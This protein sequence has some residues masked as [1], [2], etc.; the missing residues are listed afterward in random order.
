MQFGY[1]CT[2]V[3]VKNCSPAHTVTVKR[4]S[5]IDDPAVRLEICRG[6][7][8][9]NLGNTQR[10]LWHNVAHGLH[11]YRLTSQ[12][13]PLATHPITAGWNWQAEF[14]ED[15]A[16]IGAMIREYGL[17]ISSH[18][19]AY[20]VLA[21]TSATVVEAAAADLAYHATVFDL[22]GI[23]SARMTIHVGSGQGGKAK[24]LARWATNFR[25]LPL[26]VR[27]RLQIENDDT[28]FDPA[29]VLA[30]AEETGV[31]VVLD[32]HHALVNSG[33]VALDTI[34]DRIWATWPAGQ[35][36][37]IH[38]SSPRDEKSPRAH[39]DYV[40]P[41]LFRSFQQMAGAV[42][43]DVMVEAKRKDEAALRL[44]ADLGIS[45]ESVA[46]KNST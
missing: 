9:K 13:V 27:K 37:K 44:V 33:P 11:L 39:A 22:L 45:L 18:P 17:R 16:A 25:A 14:A 1:A 10:L 35:T 24:A 26:P 20:T 30:L 19:G 42:P 46:P 32:I 3:M 36:P 21:S 43:F 12:L 2:S 28:T 15:F 31:P 38:I 41:E 7:V 23:P 4:L 40:D 34:L 5:Q 29:D 6:V 8:R